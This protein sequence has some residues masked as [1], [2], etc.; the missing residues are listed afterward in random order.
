MMPSSDVA[1]DW[2][3]GLCQ[4]D[5]DRVETTDS[6]SPYEKFN[7]LLHGGAAQAVHG[8]D[9]SSRRKVPA[10]VISCTHPHCL[11]GFVCA[12]RCRCRYRY[13]YRCCCCCCCCRVLL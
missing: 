1:L 2:V 5:D 4:D 13:R 10:C 6:V 7:P 11:V 12:C 8:D 9:A 3:Y